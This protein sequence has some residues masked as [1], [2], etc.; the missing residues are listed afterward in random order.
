MPDAQRVLLGDHPHIHGEHPINGRHQ[1][2]P[3][4]SPPYTWGAP[5][6][7]RPPTS[8]TGSPPY[9][10]GA[11]ATNPLVRGRF[12]ITP[13]YMGS[14]TLRVHIASPLRD[15]P[16]IHGEHL[17]GRRSF[18]TRQGSPPY[19]WG[20]QLGNRTGEQPCG[21]TPIY[22]GST[23]QRLTRQP[24]TGDHPHIHGEHS[25]GSITINYR[26]GSP[27]YTWG[28]PGWKARAKLS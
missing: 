24:A 17:V 25:T 12:G 23:R 14:T 28:A 10:W 2:E 3:T 21:I 19:T 8:I 13:I 7:P 16:H 26:S 18:R 22:M 4:G 6:R 1:L 15:H 27:P 11:L 20:A 5:P 9:T